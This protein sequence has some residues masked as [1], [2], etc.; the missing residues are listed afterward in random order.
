[1]QKDFVD[2]LYDGGPFLSSLPKA[3]GED[4]MLVAQVGEG[5]GINSPSEADGQNRNRVNFIR[6]LVDLGFES[7]VD[8]DEVRVAGC[9][10]LVPVS[11]V[12]VLSFRSFVKTRHT[13]ASK[14]L[15]RFWLPSRT[16]IRE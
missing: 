5:A 11:A 10:G 12:R 4:G 6:S 14:L 8:Y 1:M 2:A 15:G 16:M 9:H 13:G 7:I 3:I